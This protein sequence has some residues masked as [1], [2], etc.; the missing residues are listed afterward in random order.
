MH[1]RPCV[2][3]CACGV[4]CDFNHVNAQICIDHGFIQWQMKD[5]SLSGEPSGTLTFPWNFVQG[6][7]RPG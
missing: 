6:A 5:V 7:K 4:V 3:K 2:Q 1:T